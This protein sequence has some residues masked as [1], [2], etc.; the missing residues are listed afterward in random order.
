MAK[1]NNWNFERWR[2]RDRLLTYDPGLLPVS[3]EFNDLPIIYPW[4][5]WQSQDLQSQILNLAHANGFDGSI[6]DF[7][8][9]FFTKQTVF[10]GI[11]VNFPEQGDPETLYLDTETGILYYF[12]RTDEIV[13]P[14]IAAEHGVEIVLIDNGYTNMYIPIS[15]FPLEPLFI[16]CGDAQTVID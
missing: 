9:Q 7:W 14:D 1:G 13:L 5:N 3:P 15:A 8:Q 12:K 4:V 16:N 2:T 11:L 6:T 10:T